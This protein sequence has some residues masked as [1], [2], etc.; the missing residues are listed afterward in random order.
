MIV[1]GPHPSWAAVAPRLL[2]G[3]RD[4][5][6]DLRQS[7]LSPTGPRACLLRIPFQRFVALQIGPLREF[8]PHQL[9]GVVVT[10]AAMVFFSREFAQPAVRVIR[11]GLQ[12]L[13]RPE[14]RA[15]VL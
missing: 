4:T 7:A 1:V 11:E 3:L 14:Q 2:F 5:Q 15:V 9:H 10:A 8:G 12:S 6:P 13:F